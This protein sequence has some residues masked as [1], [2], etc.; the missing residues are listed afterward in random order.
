LQAPP[1]NEPTYAPLMVGNFY[2]VK[3]ID[4]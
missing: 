3:T 1:N 4:F 2:D